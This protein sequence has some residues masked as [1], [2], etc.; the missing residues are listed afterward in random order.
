M[1]KHHPLFALLLPGAAA[2]TQ[3]TTSSEQ[4]TYSPCHWR[5]IPRPWK[6]EEQWPRSFFPSF[7][8]LEQPPKKSA[9]L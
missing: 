5:A 7:L 4:S 2:L 9:V 6:P 1:R 3:A 8:K